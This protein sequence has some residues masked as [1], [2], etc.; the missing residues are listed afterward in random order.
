MLKN[1]YAFVNLAMAA[2]VLAAVAVRFVFPSLSAEGAAFWIV[3]TSPLPMHAV[4]WT[5]FWTGLVPILVLI[6]TLTIV[7]NRFLGVAAFLQLAGRGRHLLHDLRA[8]R[9]WPPAWAPATRASTPR[10]PRRSPASYGGV[11][12]MVLAVLLTSWSRS[13]SWHGRR[14][15]LPLA[16]APRHR[17]DRRATA[18]LICVLP[19]ARSCVL[20]L[21]VLDVRG[22][23]ALANEALNRLADRLLPSGPG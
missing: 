21:S 3:R 9:R 6:E 7:S 23:R 16:P 17:P 12:F 22:M 14:L 18:V 2:F 10:T 11:V 5:K 15:D 20:D 19:G 4:L 8:R 1:A 13:A